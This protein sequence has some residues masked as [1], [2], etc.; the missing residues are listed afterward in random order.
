MQKSAKCNRQGKVTVWPGRRVPAA[1]RK[2]S[3]PVGLTVALAGSHI[4][5]PVEAVCLFN[6]TWL[7]RSEGAFSEERVME[8]QILLDLYYNTHTIS[9]I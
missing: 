2:S 3:G 7:L 5:S 9:V 1:A 4:S 6:G 8:S